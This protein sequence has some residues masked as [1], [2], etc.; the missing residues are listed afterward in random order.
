MAKDAPEG[1]RWAESAIRTAAARQQFCELLFGKARDAVQLIGEGAVG[2]NAL[3]FEL[4]C[5]G[6]HCS[7]YARCIMGTGIQAGLEA[8]G[9]CL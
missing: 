7:P 8:G 3:L 2:S 6:E 5:E 1:G 4:N 9:C